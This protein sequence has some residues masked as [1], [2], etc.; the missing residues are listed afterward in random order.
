[1]QF[2]FRAAV[3]GVKETLA[4]CSLYSPVDE[5]RRKY[6]NGALNVCR[7]EGSQK[8]VVIRAKS[9]IS[10]I[11]LVPFKP[12]ERVGGFFLAEKPGLDVIH[13]GIIVDDD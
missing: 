6:S 9:I 8:L 4:L 10:A 11:A 7:Y 1:V 5:A 13:T 2:Y 3:R 12:D